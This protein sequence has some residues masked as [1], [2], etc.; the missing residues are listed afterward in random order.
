MNQKIGYCF[1]FTNFIRRG[2]EKGASVVIVVH[3]A[4]L[5]AKVQVEHYTCLIDS[6][7]L[8]FFFFF[9]FFLKEHIEY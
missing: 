9:F 7:S 2:W 1:D 5:R 8:P 3:I 6:I 4:K